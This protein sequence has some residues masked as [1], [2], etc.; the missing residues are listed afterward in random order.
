MSGWTS[1]RSAA[2]VL[3]VPMLLW[4]CGPS[5][6]TTEPPPEGSPGGEDVTGS[7]ENQA[8]PAPAVN[9]EEKEEQKEEPRYITVQHIL[10]GFR[11]SVPGKNITR[12]REEAQTLAEDLLRRAKAGEDFD[13]LVREHTDDRPPGIYKMSNHGVPAPTGGYARGRMV[14]AFGDV[15]FPLDVG[16]IGM[17]AYDA[18]RSPYGW[19]IIKRTE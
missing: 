13:A 8:P 16:G 19:H 7:V 1:K 9:T 4:G 18:N 3:L 6:K 5:P 2:W 14:P 15:G 11:G 10:V 17:A 12:T